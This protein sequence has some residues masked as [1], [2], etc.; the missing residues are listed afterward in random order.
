MIPEYVRKAGPVAEQGWQ[1]IQE[2]YG[3]GTAEADLASN[4]WF[5]NHLEAFVA[6]TK[7]ARTVIKFNLVETE[8]FIK[9]T[10]SGE[11]Y[12]NFMLQDVYGDND[13]R[14]WSIGALEKFAAKVN[15]EGIIGDVDHLAYDE[16]LDSSIS[17][18][19]AKALIKNKAGIAKG[20]RAIVE[21]GKL[22]VR[23]LIDKRYKR[24]I[25]NAKGVS[26][27]AVISEQDENGTIVDA[28][29]LGFTFAV[30]GTPANPRA[31]IA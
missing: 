5:R 30:D 6:Q 12:I 14:K 11:E 2:Q 20:V 9:R 8:E 29:L 27:E 4:V 16:I 3:P 24:L 13:G 22:W 26:L 17:N 21:D 18:A 31:I 19:T 7:S 28:E 15:S 10:D 23:A 25:Q 1:H